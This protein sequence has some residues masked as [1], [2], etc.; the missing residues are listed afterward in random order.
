MFVFVSD[1]NIKRRQ[2]LV[3]TQTSP[4]KE[5]DNKGLKC[6]LNFLGSMAF[7]LKIYQSFTFL[8]ALEICTT[9]QMNCLKKLRCETDE[10]LSTIVM[11]Y[12]SNIQYCSYIEHI[13]FFNVAV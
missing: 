2:A 1:L 4:Y 10:Q 8:A 9:H 6:L 12:L 5:L 7:L 11:K 3:M 13:V